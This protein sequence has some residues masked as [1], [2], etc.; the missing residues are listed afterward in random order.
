MPHLCYL[1]HEE[2]MFQ[3][4]MVV[5]HFCANTKLYDDYS[6]NNIQY[7]YKV[8]CSILDN[9]LIKTIN[10]CPMKDMKYGPILWTLVIHEVWTASFQCVNL[11]K[12]DFLSLCL[13]QTNGE[14]VITFTTQFLQICNDPGKNVPSETLFL[15]NEQLFTAS[16]EQF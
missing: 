12:Q 2:I 4:N 15:F 9:S 1:L 3:P 10:L 13:N 5:A 8:L 6:M 7:S 16:V 14:N 11:L